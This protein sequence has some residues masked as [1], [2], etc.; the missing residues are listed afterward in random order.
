MKNLLIYFAAINIIAFVLFGIDK[1]KAKHGSWRITE[2]TLLDAAIL[3]GSI[4][5]YLGMKVFHHKTMHKKFKFGIPLI[6]VFH[7]LLVFFLIRWILSEIIMFNSPEPINI[8][9]IRVIIS[10]L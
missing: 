3:G 4:G 7:L 9:I 10:R 8:V 5:A 1:W 2:A 6:I